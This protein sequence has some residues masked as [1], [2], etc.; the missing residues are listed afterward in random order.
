MENSFK[1]GDNC[2]YFS[3]QYPNGTLVKI[4][5]SRN[6]GT[7]LIER[8]NAEVTKRKFQR[9]YT[10]GKDRFW[11]PSFKLK[12]LGEISDLINDLD[13]VGLF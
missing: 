10:V 12:P 8:V 6:R 13:T 5:K 3:R 1:V 11:T 2:L 7:H 4:L 9:T